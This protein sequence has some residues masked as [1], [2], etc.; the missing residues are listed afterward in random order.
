MCVAAEGSRFDHDVD[1]SRF[2]L[3]ADHAGYPVAVQPHAKGMFPE[4]H[5]RF[6]GEALALLKTSLAMP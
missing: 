5:D 2:E 4:S 6:I 1:E 3:E